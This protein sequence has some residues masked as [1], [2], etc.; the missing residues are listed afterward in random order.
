MN[1]RLLIICFLFNVVFISSFNSFAEKKEDSL[2]K[3]DIPE[4]VGRIANHHIVED[5]AYKILLIQDAHCN[6]DAQM[7]IAKILKRIYRKF[8][9]NTVFIEGASGRLLTKGLTQIANKE[10]L[11]QVMN[12]FVRSGR[13]SGMEY[14][15]VAEDNTASIFGVE[16]PELYLENKKAF[17][18]IQSL[19]T[20]SDIYVR[21]F[22]KRINIMKSRVFNPALL[23]FFN[24]YESFNNNSLSF[25]EFIKYIMKTAETYVIDLSKYPDVQNM[26]KMEKFQKEV[27][28]KKSQAERS[29]LIG[30][31]QR[32][33]KSEDLKKLAVNTLKYRINELSERKYNQYLIET[34][35]ANDIDSAS[36]SEFVKYAEYISLMD[37]IDFDKLIGQM[38]Q[39]SEQVINSLIKTEDERQLYELYRNV[40]MFNKMMKLEMSRSDLYEMRN[41]P[42]RYF[43]EHLVEVYGSLADKY[44]LTALPV[45]KIPF[46][47]LNKKA[48]RFYDLA[49]KR[50]N[51]LLKNAL[52][53]MKEN[54]V[55]TASLVIGGFHKDG[56]ADLL[57]SKK[58]SFAVI[59]PAIQ[60][61]SSPSLYLSMMADKKN[62]MQRSLINAFSENIT[63]K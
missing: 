48:M 10:I 56:I 50:D 26:F 19:R 1:K 39:A 36:F 37:E 9:S 5:S 54:G 34:S 12:D 38:E 24:N 28:F 53:T 44:S 31:L 18:D 51:A 49:I 11:K 35:K 42:G 58:I 40:E 52:E 32:K 21:E 47:E 22:M 43:Q 45:M 33:L 30:K 55:T 61:F 8:D 4:D 2:K 59:T 15:A 16:D 14:Y 23:S 6:Y 41:D 25:L 17:L 62:P 13:L 46:D 27:D 60:E 57:K 63:K 7:N 3:F 20:Y 29:Q